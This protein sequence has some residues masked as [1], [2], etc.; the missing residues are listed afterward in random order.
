MVPPQSREVRIGSIG[1]IEGSW[2]RASSTPEIVLYYPLLVVRAE[3]S[4]TETPTP[5]EEHCCYFTI[6]GGQDTPLHTTL[7]MVGRNLEGQW[8]GWE[9]THQ[10]LF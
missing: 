5:I 10:G 3:E 1:G 2:R 7:I 6:I 8:V 9:S 4:M